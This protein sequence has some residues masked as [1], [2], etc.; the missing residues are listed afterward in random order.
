MT[1]LI[2]A[3]SKTPWDQANHILLNGQ[4]K[5]NWVDSDKKKPNNFYQTNFDDNQWGQIAV[6]ANC[7][8]N[9]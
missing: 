6:P 7:E 9:G 4:W 1:M 3:F 2:V 5:F 8:V